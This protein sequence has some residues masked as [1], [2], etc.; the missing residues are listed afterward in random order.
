MNHVNLMWERVQSAGR[1]QD[2]SIVPDAVH[3]AESLASADPMTASSH[4]HNVGLRKV[5]P[6]STS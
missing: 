2:K 4:S 1:S 6:D 3:S 5:R